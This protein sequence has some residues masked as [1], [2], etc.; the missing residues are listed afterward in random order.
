MQVTTEPSVVPAGYALRVRVDAANAASPGA[1]PGLAA[2]ETV[3]SGSGWVEYVGTS[4][5][6]LACAPERLRL[7]VKTL[8]GS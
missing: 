2:V 7:W 4:R 6:D 1:L 3:R 5:Q 8:A